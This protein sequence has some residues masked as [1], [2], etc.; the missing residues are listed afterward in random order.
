MFI[1]HSERREQILKTII[2]GKDYRFVQFMQQYESTGQI[3]YENFPMNK[4]CG[5]HEGEDSTAYADIF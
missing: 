2:V 3:L 5:H 4:M 1:A